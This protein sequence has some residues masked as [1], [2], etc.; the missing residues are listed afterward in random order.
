MQLSF[1][2]T[3]YT[4]LRLIVVFI[5]TATAFGD[6]GDTDGIAKRIW[7]MDHKYTHG[8]PENCV[9]RSH[10]VKVKDDG[11]SAYVE[12]WFYNVLDQRFQEAVGYDIAGWWQAPMHHYWLQKNSD[13]AIL[14]EKSGAS[15]SSCSS[16]KSSTS[17][18]V[19]MSIISP[20]EPAF[21]YDEWSY[22]ERNT[23]LA[24]KATLK[25]YLQESQVSSITGENVGILQIPAVEGEVITGCI[26]LK[27][28]VQGKI[29]L[30]M[31]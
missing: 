28:G 2:T 22:S 31:V 18:S 9:V 8:K 6:V 1:D 21:A 16:Y 30:E 14:V 5:A 11:Q 23:V 10:N 3:A 26:A 12:A 20:D 7:E 27:N 13:Y 15:K 24:A 19:K 4:V 25:G 29:Q 17:G